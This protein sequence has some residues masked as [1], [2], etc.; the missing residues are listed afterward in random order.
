MKTYRVTESH[1]EDAP[2][3]YGEY[4]FESDKQARLWLE[5]EQK[6]KS[7]GYSKLFMDRIDVKEKTTRIV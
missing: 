6:K 4:E 1:C 5:T 2:E 7:N 3:R